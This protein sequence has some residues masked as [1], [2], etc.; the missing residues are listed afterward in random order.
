MSIQR[1]NIRNVIDAQYD[2][3]GFQISN[4]ATR[5]GWTD[6]PIQTGFGMGLSPSLIKTFFYDKFKDANGE[7]PYQ[8]ETNI[9]G[10]GA[11]QGNIITDTGL[12]HLQHQMQAMK[13][14]N[15]LLTYFQKM[16]DD[17]GF[18]FGSISFP[19]PSA[20]NVTGVGDGVGVY[21]QNDISMGGM[22]GIE[23]AQASVPEWPS[24]GLV[25]ERI[26]YS[27]EIS[28]GSTS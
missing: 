11:Q 19:P 28:V 23:Y 5:V 17:V 2:I 21:K 8:D 18:T 1:R 6:K 15:N 13:S 20:T 26:H 10:N 12:K 22:R 4:G 16:A 9:V 27:G 3:D 25:A 14:D 7:Y 24:S